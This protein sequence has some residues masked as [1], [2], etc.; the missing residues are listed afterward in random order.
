MSE[1][2]PYFSAVAA[3]NTLS[4]VSPL[5][6]SKKVKGKPKKQPKMSPR[7]QQINQQLEKP[8]SNQ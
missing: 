6:E 2:D 8:V 4:E 1:K 5:K 3:L 7:A